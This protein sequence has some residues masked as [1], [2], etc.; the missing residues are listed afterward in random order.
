[1]FIQIP[2]RWP[3]GTQVDFVVRYPKGR[4]PFPSL[5][6][7]KAFAA[8]QRALPSGWAAIDAQGTLSIEERTH[9]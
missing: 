2:T 7:A 5:F 3:K 9:D 8:E 1:M 6:E 4:K